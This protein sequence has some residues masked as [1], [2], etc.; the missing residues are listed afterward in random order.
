VAAGEVGAF[1]TEPDAPLAYL[2]APFPEVGAHLLAREAA[3][4]LGYLDALFPR[5]ANVRKVAGAD[6][7]VYAAG[8]DQ[9]L[10]HR[11]FHRRDIGGWH[12]QFC[13]EKERPGNRA[14]QE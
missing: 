1:I 2:G 6:G 3:G 14:C 5:P 8:G 4:A 10:V 11:G 9:P 13:G 7:A 12:C